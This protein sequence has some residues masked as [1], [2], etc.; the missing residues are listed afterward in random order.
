MNTAHCTIEELELI[1][2]HAA[3]LAHRRAELDAHIEACDKCRKQ[4][5]HIRHWYDDAEARASAITQETEDRVYKIASIKFSGSIIEL[6][7]ESR[8]GLISASRPNLIALAA[9]DAVVPTRYTTAATLSSNDGGTM[10]HVVRDNERGTFLI[11]VHCDEVSRRSHILLTFDSIHGYYLT[12]DDGECELPADASFKPNELR[13]FIHLPK[14]TVVLS[15]EL[16]DELR[17]TPEITRTMDGRS[18]LFERVA[19]GVVRISSGM[20]EEESHPLPVAIIFESRAA[21]RSIVD[22]AV[23]L[24]RNEVQPETVIKIF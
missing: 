5:E 13:A 21:L 7:P 24:D 11:Q 4:L 9:Q 2:L 23:I 14:I 22:G 15:Q 20:P 3:T 12:N 19:T 8:S 1:A 16:I 6:F 18:V 10:I 17:H